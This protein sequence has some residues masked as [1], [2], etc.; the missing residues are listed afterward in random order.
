[1]KWNTTDEPDVALDG[2]QWCAMIGPNIQEG[3]AGFGDT[4]HEARYQLRLAIAHYA[5]G[6]ADGAA[7]ERARNAEYTKHVEERCQ[8]WKLECATAYERGAAEM[9][10][11]I[12]AWL[13]EWAIGRSWGYSRPCPESTLA[14]TFAGLFARGEHLSETGNGR[15]NA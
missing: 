15:E 1:M 4:P 6:K 11:K 3:L 5:Q 9:Q 7:E 8:S 14:R 2:N 13:N 12:V 10:A